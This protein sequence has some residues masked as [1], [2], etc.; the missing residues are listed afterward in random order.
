MSEDPYKILGVEKG[1]SQDKIQKAYRKLAKKL[2]PDLN[3]G[4]AQAEEKFKRVSTAYGLLGDEEKRG[5]YDRGEIDETGAERPQHHFY[6]DYADTDAAHQYS[7]STGFE[8]FGDSSDLFSELFGRGAR[9]GAQRVRLRGADVRYHLKVDFLDAVRG[10]KRRVTMPDGANLDISIPA[11]VLDG[12]T[13][14][15][16]GKGMPGPNGGEPG[17]ALIEIKV[18]SHPVFKRRGMDIHIDVPITID[19]AVL[20]GKVSVPTVT[21]RVTMTVP[22]GANSGQTLRLKG[23]GV[24]SPKGKGDQLV[25][26]KVVLPERIDPDLEEFM[27]SWREKHGYDPRP[28]LKGAA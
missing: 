17:D 2:H 10:A 13:I 3:P 25:H 20:G 27:R 23:K 19:E 11:G 26:L 28:H 9:G 7:S 14:R 1:A 24:V 22:K 15:L 16:K 5:R 12:Q 18:T 21:G 6:R 4:D 8:D